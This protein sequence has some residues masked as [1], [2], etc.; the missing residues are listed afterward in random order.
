MDFLLA[1]A[2]PGAGYG[3]FDAAAIVLRE[4]FEALLVVVALLTLVERSGGALRGR[5]RLAV[6]AG[7]AGGLLLA[8]LLGF[9]LKRWLAA[10]AADAGQELVSGLAGLAA[11]VLMLSVG[12]WVHEKATVEG[13]NRFLREQVGSA[14]ARGSLLSL[15]L[16]AGT[17]VLREGVETVVFFAGMAASI[18]PG[19]LALG[20][21]GAL[22]LLVAAG[23]LALRLGWRLPVHAVFLV[24]SLLLDVMAF[25]F[26]GSSV[27]ALQEA[28]LVPESAAPVPG[29]GF[30]GLYPTWQSLVAQL[31]VLAIVGAFWLQVG[32]REAQPARS[33]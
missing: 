19:Q 31:V 4:G 28:G 9:A 18:A 32:R 8:L 13:W 26:A 10:E 16:I 3:A 1:A 20:L 11:V 21:G 5:Q 27:H 24:A 22:A 12:T 25:K 15:G 33:S 17:A 30:L 14:L 6:A 29:W 2:L 7:T 23:L